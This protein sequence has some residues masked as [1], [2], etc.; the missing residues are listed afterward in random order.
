MGNDVVI[1]PTMIKIHLKFTDQEILYNIVLYVFNT[2]KKHINQGGIF[3]HIIC[4][5][6]GNNCNACNNVPPQSRILLNPD[7]LLTG[8]ARR[9]IRAFSFMDRPEIERSGPASARLIGIFPWPCCTVSLDFMAKLF[10]I[11]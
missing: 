11:E 5:E 8:K 6:K 4:N 10:Y 1:C 3:W 2:I 9:T 7:C